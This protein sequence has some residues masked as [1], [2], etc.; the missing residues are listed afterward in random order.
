[1]F[2]FLFFEGFDIREFWKHSI[3]VAVTSR[4]QS[5]QI[6]LDSPDDCFA[7]GLLHDRGYKCFRVIS[8]YSNRNRI[9]L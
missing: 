7:A 8:D 5:E 4:Y 6:K 9:G 3:A 1:M 2:W